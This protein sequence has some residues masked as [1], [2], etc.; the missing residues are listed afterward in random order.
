MESE[1]QGRARKV[2]WSL[3][4]EDLQVAL[5]LETERLY[6][7]NLKESG[8]IPIPFQIWFHNSVTQCLWTKLHLQ[9]LFLVQLDWG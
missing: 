7:Q 5:G 8:L 9:S 2:D 3:T 6:H 1:G 4:L